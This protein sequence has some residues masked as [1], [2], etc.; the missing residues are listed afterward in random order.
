MAKLVI[1]GSGKWVD[2]AP[3]DEVTAKKYAE[4]VVL[5]S[6]EYQACEINSHGYAE[7]FYGSANIYLNDMLICSVDEMIK[8]SKAY[9]ESGA[10]FQVLSNRSN[11]PLIKN[12]WVREQDCTGN[13]VDADIL[14]YPDGGESI[15]PF[16]IKDFIKN[17]RVTNFGLFD[18]MNWNE[19]RYGFYAIESPSKWDD[20]YILFN[21]QRHEFVIEED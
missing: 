6:S 19:N 1:S 17:I 18:M 21:G 5:K 2:I 8:L 20:T 7:G 14:D 10:F 12:A 11:I 13:F 4:L 9:D 15:S 16:F 3:L